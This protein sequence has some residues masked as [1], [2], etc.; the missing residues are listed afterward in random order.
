MLLFRY[1]FAF[2]RIQ[3]KEKMCVYING[4]GHKNDE[5]RKLLFFERH[6]ENVGKSKKPV[7]YQCGYKMYC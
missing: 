2:K 3:R 7:Q 1:L 5:Q 4:Y 6:I